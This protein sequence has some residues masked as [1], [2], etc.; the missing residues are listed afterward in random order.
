[1]ESGLDMVTAA[2]L[3]YA[4]QSLGKVRWVLAVPED[5]AFQKPEDLAGKIIATELVNVTRNYFAACKVPVKLSSPG[6]QQKS[7]LPCWPTRL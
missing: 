3:V 4:K 1:V 6:A 7:S 2:E 5:S